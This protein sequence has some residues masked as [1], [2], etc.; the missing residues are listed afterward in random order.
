MIKIKGTFKLINRNP[1]CIYKGEEVGIADGYIAGDI[2]A[3][4]EGNEYLT[5]NNRNFGWYNSTGE[6]H[7]DDKYDFKRP[8]TEEII[9]ACVKSEPLAVIASEMGLIEMTREY[10]EIEEDEDT[11]VPTFKFHKFEVCLN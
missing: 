4:T 7:M 5:S 3:E 11:Y 2:F 6:H 8:T 9:K 10:L 1:F